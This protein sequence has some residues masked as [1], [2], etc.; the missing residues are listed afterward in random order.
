MSS[1]EEAFKGIM[2]KPGEHRLK[3][4]GAILTDRDGKVI[5]AEVDLTYNE[6]RPEPDP[7]EVQPE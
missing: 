4:G 5:G 3:L 1:V 6:Q 7:R 2:D